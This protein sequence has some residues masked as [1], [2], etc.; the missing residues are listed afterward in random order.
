MV[1]QLFRAPRF[2]VANALYGGL[3]SIGM[4]PNRG[5]GVCAASPLERHRS[6]RQWRRGAFRAHAVPLRG[7][8]ESPR[9]VPLTRRLTLIPILPLRAAAFCAVVAVARR[10]AKAAPDRPDSDKDQNCKRGDLQNGLHRYLG[11][12]VTRFLHLGARPSKFTHRATLLTSKSRTDTISSQY[13]GHTGV[14]FAATSE[15]PC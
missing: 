13:R 15:A 8:T 9:D 14:A 11:T 10:C 4:R 3:P 7:T 12:G 6:K 1:A 2:I 5:G